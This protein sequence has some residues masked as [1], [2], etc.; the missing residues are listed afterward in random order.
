MKYVRGTLFLS[1]IFV[2]PPYN[3]VRYFTDD[4]NELTVNA[5]DMTSTSKKNEGMNYYVG[6]KFVE[7]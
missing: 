6:M 2:L 1:W 5:L 4:N 3:G 7:C